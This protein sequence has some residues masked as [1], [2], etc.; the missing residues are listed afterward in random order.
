MIDLKGFIYKKMKNYLCDGLNEDG[1]KK[2]LLQTLLDVLV[3]DSQFKEMNNSQRIVGVGI[4]TIRD[5]INFTIY[6]Q[7]PTPWIEF[8]IIMFAIGFERTNSAS[9]L[10]L[11][12]IILMI[13]MLMMMLYMSIR[14]NYVKYVNLTFSRAQIYDVFYAVWILSTDRSLLN[15]KKSATDLR[16][17]R[18]ISPRP[19]RIG[20]S[21]RSEISWSESHEPVCHA[22]S[23]KLENPEMRFDI[24]DLYIAGN[25]NFV[26]RKS[27]GSKLGTYVM[28]FRNA[29]EIRKYR[30]TKIESYILGYRTLGFH[31]DGYFTV[32]VMISPGFYHMHNSYLLEAT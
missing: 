32:G 15:W 26:H 11:K 7:P 29:D 21:E 2:C 1:V 6:I 9:T 17:F 16:Q 19:L 30:I 13:A 24:D 12:I 5:R 27:D 20:K 18:M 25:A 14:Y 28:S 22:L 23:Y 10:I 3:V 8:F 31:G 4:T